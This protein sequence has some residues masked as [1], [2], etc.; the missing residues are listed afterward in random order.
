[1]LEALQEKLNDAFVFWRFA[2]VD[3]LAAATSKKLL[4]VPGEP[5]LPEQRRAIAELAAAGNPVVRHPAEPL[6][7]LAQYACICA[8]T[9]RGLCAAL[10]PP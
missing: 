7:D 2:G 8:G 10:P 3:D 1:M 5:M 4:I 9:E 6:P